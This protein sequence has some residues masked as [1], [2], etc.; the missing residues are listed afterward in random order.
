MFT[1]HNTVKLLFPLNYVVYFV[2][3]D[4]VLDD[5]MPKLLSHASLRYGYQHTK[6]L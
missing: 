6:L 1:C 4:S 3:A 2:S 5:N